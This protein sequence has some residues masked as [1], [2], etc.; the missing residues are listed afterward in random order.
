MGSLTVTWVHGLCTIALHD[1]C[2][3]FRSC[4]LRD[5]L[6]S[7]CCYHTMLLIR[8][9]RAADAGVAA[10]FAGVCWNCCSCCNLLLLACSLPTAVKQQPFGRCEQATLAAVSVAAAAGVLLSVLLLKDSYALSDAACRSVQKSG[11][12]LSSCIVLGS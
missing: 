9:V 5:G 6:I 12:A 11:L 8:V 10:A 2:P 1:G 3:I 4:R 7:E